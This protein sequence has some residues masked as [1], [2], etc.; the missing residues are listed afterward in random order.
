MLA[1]TA[2]T[3]FH[4]GKIANWDARW[5]II[6]GSVDDRNSD[7]RDPNNPLYI[8]QSRYSAAQLYIYNGQL[9][10]PEYNDIKETLNINPII[11]SYIVDQAK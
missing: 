9:N 3:P 6:Q 8:P 5:K 2:G 4:K 1:V 10:K 11:R 7:E